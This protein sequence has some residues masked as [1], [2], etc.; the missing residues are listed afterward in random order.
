[1]YSSSVCGR[2][3]AACRVA[4]KLSMS[5]RFMAVAGTAAGADAGA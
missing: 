1:V 2:G 3:F 4:K 5:W